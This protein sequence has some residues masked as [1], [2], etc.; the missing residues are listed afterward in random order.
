MTDNDLNGS[1]LPEPCIIVIFGVTGDL[2]RRE[3][4]PALFEF[5]RQRR[6]MPGAYEWLLYDAMGGDQTLFPRVD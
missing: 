2:A 4:M 5:T 3:L 6:S 1:S